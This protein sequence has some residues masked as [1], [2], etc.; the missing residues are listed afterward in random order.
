MSERKCTVAGLTVAAR[1]LVVPREGKGALFGVFALRRETA[2]T[3][4]QAPLVVR[5]R[6]GHRTADFVGVRA[7]MGM[8]P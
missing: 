3:V 5:D 4:D 7:D 6:R 2:G 8:P 1:R